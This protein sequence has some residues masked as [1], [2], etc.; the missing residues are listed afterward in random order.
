[1]K[2]YEFVILKESFLWAIIV[3]FYR[4]VNFTSEKI[5]FLTIIIMKFLFIS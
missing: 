1:M 2:N 5:E 4:D 3:N